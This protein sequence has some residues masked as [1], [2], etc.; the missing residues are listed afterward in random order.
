MAG[1]RFGDKK[2]RHDLAL[3]R[4]QRAEPA[5]ARLDQADIG[6]DEAIEKIARGLAA[7]LDHAPVGEKRCFHMKFSGETRVLDITPQRKPLKCW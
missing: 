4:Q 1:G 5:E 6:G 7:D 2:I 3:R